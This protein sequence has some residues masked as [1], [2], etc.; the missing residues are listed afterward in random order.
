[1]QA[2]DGLP[3]ERPA[4]KDVVLGLIVIG[5]GSLFVDDFGEVDDVRSFRFDQQAGPRLV[6]RRHR[7]GVGG[8]A[9]HHDQKRRARGPAAL[10]QDAHVVEQM[11]ALW[12]PLGG[13]GRRLR[14]RGAAAGEPKRAA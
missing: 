4:L 9:G 3:R 8:D 1:M 5:L 11:D 10:V 12:L 14:R 13:R 6:D 7:E 2:I